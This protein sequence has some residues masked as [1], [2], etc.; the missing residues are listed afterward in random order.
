MK[1]SGR[2]VVLVLVCVGDSFLCRGG[3]E[4]GAEGGLSKSGYDTSRFVGSTILERQFTFFSFL[5]NFD[6]F[7]TVLQAQPHAVL[8]SAIEPV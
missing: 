6:I 4:R 7:S 5:H 2:E 8:H 1:A 3:G